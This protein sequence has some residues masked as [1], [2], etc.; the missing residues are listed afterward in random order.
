ENSFGDLLGLYF[1][2]EDLAVNFISNKYKAVLFYIHNPYNTND[3]TQEE[4]YV[5]DESNSK[6]PYM[7]LNKGYGNFRSGNALFPIHEKYKTKY[8]NNKKIKQYP[9]FIT[10]F[11]EYYPIYKKFLEDDNFNDDS[12]S[13]LF[14]K[15]SFFEEKA[16]Y[17]SESSYFVAFDINDLKKWLEISKEINNRKL[18]SDYS[19]AVKSV[20]NIELSNSNDISLTS[21]G[22]EINAVLDKNE[23]NNYCY[24]SYN[25]AL[26][27][28][29]NAVTFSSMFLDDVAGSLGAI[30]CSPST[31]GAVFCYKAASAATNLITSLG[32][33]ELQKLRK[34]PERGDI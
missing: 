33:N 16:K 9:D 27:N 10:Y 22:I 34:W 15:K 20:D 7:A 31:A 8:I 26:N 19:M 2:N 12:D 32:I 24:Q 29:I 1:L 18:Y 28:V 5:Y 25:P 30:A 4:K 6:Y 11:K 14:D 23:K 13:E 17:Y 21:F 3:K